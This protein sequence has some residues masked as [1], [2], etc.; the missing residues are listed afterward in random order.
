MGL[1]I[2]IIIN[3]IGVFLLAHFLPGISVDSNESILLVAIVL[4]LLNTFVKP[5]LKFLTFPI[6]LIT[7]GLFLLV[8]NAFIVMLADHLIAGFRVENFWW[9]LIFSIGLAI[10]NALF[11]S[12]D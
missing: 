1:L 9:A 11:D 4:I 3:A 8:I 5:I 12:S 6:T 2:R 7:L 10:I